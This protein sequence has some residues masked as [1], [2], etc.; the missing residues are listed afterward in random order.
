MLV[1]AVVLGS[2]VV[3]ILFGFLAG[4]ALLLVAITVCLFYLWGRGWDRSPPG[5]AG[6]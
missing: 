4:I 2:I 5:R 1:G 6:F 3:G